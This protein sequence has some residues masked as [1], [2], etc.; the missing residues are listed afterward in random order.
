MYKTLGKKILK[1]LNSF[2][3]R[4]FLK[5]KFT[6]EYLFFK[7][8]DTLED[9]LN[10][11]NVDNYSSMFYYFHKYLDKDLKQLRGYFNSEFRG[12]G[13]DAF[14]SI[15]YFIFSLKKPVNILEI[16]VYRGQSLALFRKLSNKNNIEANIYGVS[17]LNNLGDEY[18]DYL[19]IDYQTDIYASF[20]KFNL[21]KPNLVK[22]LSQDQEIIDF[23][24]SKKWD[25][26]YVDGSHDFDVVINDLY[27][28]I[29]SLNI[30]GVLAVDDSNKNKNYD[31]KYI[32][33]KFG[34]SSSDGH[35]G[36]TKAL[37]KLLNERKDIKKLISIGHINFLI[38]TI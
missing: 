10:L 20:E 26:I 31:Y 35:S 30:E 14:F 33:N 25:L 13:E 8:P 27:V 24:K 34:I 12:F 7:K 11:N 4:R 5:F 23:I 28:S 6:K 29:E 38:K 2:I 15:W 17:P 1:K 21:E 36:P 16:G 19:N 37:D 18:S 9:I 22:G 32:E 3:K